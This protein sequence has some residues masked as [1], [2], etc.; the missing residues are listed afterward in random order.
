METLEYKSEISKTFSVVR[1]FS[2]NEKKSPLID[3]ETL[4]TEETMNTF[5]DA[6]L[7]FKSKMKVKAEIISTITERMDKLTWFTNLDEESLML[8]NDLISAAKDVHSSLIRQYVSLTP[9]R[10]KGIAIEEIKAWKSSIDEL[11]ESYEDLESVFFFLPEMPDFV[12]TT[13]QLS[14]V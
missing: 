13:K 8:L 5:L 1:S 7:T 3:E 14:L 10:K 9:L 11:K 6:I 2:F 4:N 12:E